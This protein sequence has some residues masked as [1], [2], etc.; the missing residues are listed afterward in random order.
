MKIL[1]IN[2]GSSSV[3]YQLYDTALHAP[4]AKGGITRIGI[5]GDVKHTV[6]EKVYR[7]QENIPDHESAI[8]RIIELLTGPDFGVIASMAEVDAVGHRVVHGGETFKESVLVTED[9]IRSIEDVIPLAPLHNPAAISGIRACQHVMGDIPQVVVF[10][11][12][13]HQTMSPTA[14]LYAI[15]YEYYEKYKIR[16]YGFH[17]T[18]HRY[19]AR[20]AA[21]LLGRPVE[22]LK[23]IS[24]HLGNGSSVCAI[25]YGK[26]IDTS[27][28][29]TPLAGLPMGTRSGDID[30]AVLQ[31]LMNQEDIGI[32]EVMNILNKKSGMLG[33]S[34]ITSDYVDLVN[35]EMRHEGMDSERAWRALSMFN[36]SVRKLIGAYAAAMKGVDAVIFTGGIGENNYPLRRYMATGLDFMGLILDEEKN[37]GFR[38]EGF[39]STD[40]SPG[41]IMVIPTE[42]EMMIAT[43]TERIVSALK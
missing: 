9:V 14:F 37:D 24:C 31:F 16:R 27:M 15:P 29:F 7:A 22:E 38:S 32:D 5:D 40:D 36:Y 26:S 8:K 43:D 3:K 2:A 21:E 28:G 18:S 25:R 42:E 12:A 33:V 4:V 39:I 30:P 19:I 23:L 6:G 17:G 10:D 20:R 13:F 35:I 41:K 1:V 34:E 11:T